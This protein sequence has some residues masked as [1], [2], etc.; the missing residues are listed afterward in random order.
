MICFKCNDQGKQG[1]IYAGPSLTHCG[2]TDVACPRVYSVREQQYLLMRTTHFPHF[3]Q[4][5][6][7][8]AT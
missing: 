4:Q 5:L 8:F 7:S 6:A 3:E 2:F 1:K